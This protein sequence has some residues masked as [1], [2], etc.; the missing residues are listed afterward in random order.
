MYLDCI[1]LR[2][3][4]FF[5]NK[6]VRYRTAN[7]NCELVR[8]DKFSFIDR[9]KIYSPVPYGTTGSTGTV[10]LYHIIFFKLK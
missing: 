6:P 5:A 3:V 7:D 1:F 4:L 2:E 8:F 10:Q 9:Q